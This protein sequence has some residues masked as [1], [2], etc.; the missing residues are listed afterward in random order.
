MKIKSTAIFTFIIVLAL[1]LYAVISSMSLSQDVA[2]GK[3]QRTA[4]EA[5]LAR[6][7]RENAELEYEIAHSDDDATIESIARSKLGLVRPGEKIFY[8]ISQ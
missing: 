1:I 6:L 8:D 7:Q 5:E 3:A 2:A 4:L